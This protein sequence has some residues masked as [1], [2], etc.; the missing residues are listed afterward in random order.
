MTFEEFKQLAANPPRKDEPTV[1][2]IRAYLVDIDAVDEKS[3]I[4][5][6]EQRTLSDEEL[7]RR[8]I[9]YPTL[10]LNRYHEFYA[11]NLTDAETII[12]EQADALPKQNYI[13]YC[14][15]VDEL[16]FGEN[17]F[18]DYVS[19]RTYDAD[20]TLLDM[21]L[22]STFFNDE[23]DDYRHFRGR[24][25]EQLRF[26]EGDIVEVFS[27]NLK[28]V[29]LAIVASV[30]FSVERCYRY[31]LRGVKIWRNR[32]QELNEK[33]LTRLC[34]NEWYMLDD[35]DD[36]YAVIVGPADIYTDSDGKQWP[37]WPHRHASGLCLFKPHFPI[38]ED[39]Q[40]SLLNYYQH[41]RSYRNET[42]I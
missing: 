1:F 28:Q 7:E 33:E 8:R 29:E 42:T 5:E 34:F 3:G 15:V 32:N 4:T 17:S 38:P 20:G 12:K 11:Q 2:R 31:A 23:R 14:F 6:D 24:T 27:S 37:H 26:H 19:S 30:P 25:P 40:C 41:Y 36:T 18:A 10:E 39:I 9:Y 21:S 22:C 35:S 13:V 16:P